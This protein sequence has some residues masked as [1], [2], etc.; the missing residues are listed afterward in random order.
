MWLS[1]TLAGTGPRRR[2]P[3]TSA[4]PTR[5]RGVGGRLNM[6]DVCSEL[7]GRDARRPGL[8]CPLPSVS[9]SPRRDPVRARALA[10]SSRAPCPGCRSVE[11]RRRGLPGRRQTAD[12]WRLGTRGRRGPRR[13][14]SPRAGC[15]QVPRRPATETRIGRFSMVMSQECGSAPSGFLHL[16]TRRRSRRRDLVRPNEAVYAITDLKGRGR[17]EAL[18]VETGPEPSRAG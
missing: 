7:P 17:A 14:A 5:R 15:R 8:G 2:W 12:R 1:R 11:R 18:E 13:T 9:L 6:C 4:T 3:P 10:C 16:V